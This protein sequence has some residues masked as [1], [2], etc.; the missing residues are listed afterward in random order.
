MNEKKRKNASKILNRICPEISTDLFSVNVYW[1]RTAYRENWNYSAHRHSFFELHIPLEGRAEYTIENSVVALDLHSYALF[2][3]QALHKLNYT[4]EDFSEFVFGFDIVSP[5]KLFSDVSKNSFFAGGTTPYLHTAIEHMLKNASNGRIGFKDA[6][7]HQ[8]I[9]LCIDVFQQITGQIT[10][11]DDA[12][13]ND[14][15][16]DLAIKYID[17][18]VSCPVTC[19]DVADC[20]HISLRHLNRLTEKALFMSVAQLILS[21]KI[22]FAKKLMSDPTKGLVSV[23]EETGF[24]S[25]QQFSKAFKRIEGITPTQ[26]KKD[27]GK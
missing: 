27:L 23:A 10:A 21:R 4:S 9:C 13:T 24:S 22:R 2:S 19:T 5:Q 11:K 18:N 8:L 1:C 14:M 20:V 7:K 3:P 25:Q 6:I 12:I 17:D 26:Y 15:R 16:I